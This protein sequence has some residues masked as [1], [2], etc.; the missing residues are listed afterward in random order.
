MLYLGV[1]F[2]ENL[3]WQHHVNNFL[4]KL[5]RAN[6]LLLKIR[7]FVNDKVLRSIHFAIFGFN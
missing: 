1:K 2:D 4:A 3:I 6:N 7:E 5:N